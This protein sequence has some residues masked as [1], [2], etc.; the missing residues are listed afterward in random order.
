MTPDPSKYIKFFGLRTHGILPN[1]EPA[2]EIVYV[3]S[4]MMIVDDKIALIGSANINDRSMM[5][6]RDSELA[7]VVEDPKTEP[8]LMDGLE[9][10]A[11]AFAHSLRT[12]CWVHLFGFQT[13]EEVK[14]PLSPGMWD[15]I[16]SQTEVVLT[17][18]AK[19]LD[20]QRR[21]RML[22]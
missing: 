20:L 18:L 11:S 8:S 2:T 15:K 12:T 6:S 14:D 9:Y 5:G 10:K 4:K 16:D 17:D 19:H 7:V 13:L 21:L 3:H 1:G 22:S